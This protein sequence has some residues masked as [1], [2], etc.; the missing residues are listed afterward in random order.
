MLGRGNE[1][2]PPPCHG[3]TSGGAHACRTYACVPCDAHPSLILY[4]VS[5]V[6]LVHLPSEV[7]RQSLANCPTR[8]SDGTNALSLPVYAVLLVTTWA[9]PF[10]VQSRRT[11]YAALRLP[12][13][14]SNKLDGP[15][16]RCH[17]R[18]KGR[19][20]SREPQRV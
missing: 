9:I 6:L 12:A 4:R 2:D 19:F 13:P 16:V 18:G 20:V 15:M 14:L 1:P 5:T 3:N 7:R 10:C 11:A 17:R 8:H